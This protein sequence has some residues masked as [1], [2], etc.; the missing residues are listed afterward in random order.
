MI[1][2]ESEAAKSG[3]EYEVTEVPEPVSNNP[4][5]EL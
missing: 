3:I 4:V 2:P 5:H 1:L